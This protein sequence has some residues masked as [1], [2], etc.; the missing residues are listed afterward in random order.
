MFSLNIRQVCFCAFGILFL[1]QLA[2]S[3][4]PVA[5]SPVP[6]LREPAQMQSNSV[7]A[8]R[9]EALMKAMGDGVIPPAIRRS[10]R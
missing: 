1:A 4:G 3:A 6:S 9:R 7:Y 10:Q 8:A 2:R 5:D